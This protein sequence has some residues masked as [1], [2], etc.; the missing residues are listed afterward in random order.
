MIQF[1]LLPDSIL[2]QLRAKKIYTF[3]TRLTLL[4]SIGAII[5]MFGLFA[6]V[7]IVQKNSISQN[8]TQISLK[9][10]ALNKQTYFNAILK[11]NDAI[12]ILPS[13]YDSRP[14]I[15][16]LSGY[17]SLITPAQVSISNL[18]LNFSTDTFQLSGTADSINTINT[19][20]DTLKFCEYNIDNNS[21]NKLAFSKVVLSSYAYSPTS[22]TGESF[23]VT[24]NF[25]ANIFNAK[26]TDVQL[27]VPSQITTRSNIDQPS[28]LF[29]TQP[30]KV[31]G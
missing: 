2:Y 23:S 1:N 31:N 17:L 5:I 26:D 25:D 6:E 7:K 16:R 19:F 13:L 9:N 15:T 10:T 18:S 11:I 29:V 28:D 22:T 21:T 14:D 3:I 30:S 12:K 4:I 24:A 20:V 27:V 8:N